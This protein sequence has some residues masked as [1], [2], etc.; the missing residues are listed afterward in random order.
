MNEHAYVAVEEKGCKLVPLAVAV[1]PIG[2]LA[3]VLVFLFAVH[4]VTE[5]KHD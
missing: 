2:E 1:L 4:K 5:Y 3:H